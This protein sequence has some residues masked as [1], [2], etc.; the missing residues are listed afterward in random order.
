M[1]HAE[2]SKI[3]LFSIADYAWNMDAYKWD[4]SWR[5]AVYNLMP[6]HA[7]AL[8]TFVSHNS[9]LGKNEHDFRREESKHIRP[10]LEQLLDTYCREGKLNVA[11]VS[12]V[13]EECERMIVSADLLLA[14]DENPALIKE[15]TPWLMQFKLLGEYG[16]E[17][18]HM[19][20]A[21]CG[22]KRWNLRKLFLMLRLYRY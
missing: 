2:A 11:A 15:I 14:A 5:R 22:G 18:L 12:A 3:A 21:Q 19:L 10:A 4:A 8:Q 9:G 1:E 7:A 13:T 20:A 6:C 17:V 16:R